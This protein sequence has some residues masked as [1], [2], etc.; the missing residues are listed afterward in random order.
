LI[1]TQLIGGESIQSDFQVTGR[2][3]TEEFLQAQ[4]GLFV[5]NRLEFPVEEFT[6]IGI[7]DLVKIEKGLVHIIDWKTSKKGI[8]FKSNY[9]LAAKKTR[10]LKFPLQA[11]DDVN[12]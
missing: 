10:R 8:R 7:P 5:E 6:V 11:I 9:D 4:D 3:A 2:L 1:R 12:G